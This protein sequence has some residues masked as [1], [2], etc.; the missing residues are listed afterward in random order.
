MDKAITGKFL[1]AGSGGFLL[2]I[3]EFMYGGDSVV[4]TTM[5][6]VLFFILMDWLSGWS[7][8]RQD[9]TYASR[10]GLDGVIRT[11]FMLLLP[12]GGHFLD[13]VFNSPGIVFGVLTFGLLYHTIKSMTANSIRAGWGDW[14][15][16]RW[17][18]L[19]TKWVE[20]EIEAKVSRALKRL[21]ERGAS[22]GKAD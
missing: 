15:P 8:S 17:L 3:F 10:Y 20:S 1:A 16:T 5:T 4:L 18:E 13:Q 19:L 6:A 2:P 14:I 9:K 21:E 7:A 22:G 11:F 12:A